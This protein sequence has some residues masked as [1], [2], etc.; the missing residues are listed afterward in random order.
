MH[1]RI[2][3]VWYMRNNV[4]VFIS[5]WWVFNSA[6]HENHMNIKNKSMPQSY[7][8]TLQ[9]GPWSNIYVRKHTYTQNSTSQK[10]Q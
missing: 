7:P 10:F 9:R 3:D 1:Y 5:A 6:A 4:N 2:Q 8:Q